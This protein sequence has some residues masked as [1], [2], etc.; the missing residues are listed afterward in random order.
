MRAMIAG[1]T[2]QTGRRVVDRLLARG[3]VVRVLTRRAERARERLGDRVE[4]HEGDVRDPGSLRGI[5]RDVDVAVITTG[6]RSYVGA[7]GG[8]QVDAVGNRHLVAALQGVEHIVCLS[9]FGLDRDALALRA[10]SLALGDYFRWKALAETTVRSSSVPWTLVRPVELRNR[11]PKGAPRLNQ[12]DPLS[13]LRTVSRDLVADVLVH[14]C[15]HPDAM[16]K[17]FELCEGGAATSSL[18]AQLA[19]MAGEDLR[20]RPCTTP[21]FGR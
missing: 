18:D 10:F 21:L 13:L 2:G 4:V 17:T 11:P 12:A 14:C 3:D 5:A 15:R 9:A 8:E 16:H 1:G 20:P 7:N 19:A 6:S